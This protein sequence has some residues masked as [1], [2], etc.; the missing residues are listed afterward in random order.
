L[1]IYDRLKQKLSLVEDKLEISEKHR[2]QLAEKLAAIDADIQKIAPGLNPISI[3]AIRASKGR[4]I[5]HGTL[6]NFLLSVLTERAPGYVPTFE[7]IILA[8][9]VFSLKFA[10]SELRRKWASNSLFGALYR[11]ETA[12]LIE[13]GPMQKNPKSGPSNTWRIKI[14]APVRLSDL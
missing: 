2:L 4:Y 6:G 5:A 10:N 14:E 1:R 9:E 3:A 11:L 13:K 12:G 7:L 8:I